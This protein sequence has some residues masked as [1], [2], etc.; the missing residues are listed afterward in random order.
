[1]NSKKL[2]TVGIVVLNYNN[3]QD[4][5]ECVDSILDQ[6][7]D[8]FELCIVDNHSTD[9]SYTQLLQW[10]ENNFSYNKPK[11]SPIFRSNIE[12]KVSSTTRQKHHKKVHIIQSDS[13]SGYAAGNNIGLQYLAAFESITYFW[14][15]NNDT[16]ITSDALTK[17]NDSFKAN[18]ATQ[19]GNTGILAQKL[20][21]YQHPKKI[22]ALGGYLTRPFMTSNHVAEGQNDATSEILE[23]F[24]TQVEYPVGA[25]MFFSRRF[26]EHA[27]Y[28]NEGYFLYYEE[29]D[30]IKRSLNKAQTLG[31]CLDSIVFHKEG[32]TTSKSE[33]ISRLSYAYAIRNRVRYAWRNEQLYFP[34]TLLYTILVLIKHLIS[35]RYK[36][37]KRVVWPK[38]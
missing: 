16:V 19:S 6:D 34:L 32:A 30:W 5:M 36:L 9:D 4:T 8:L 28:M 26:L 35:G 13:N 1:M 12:A 3:A 22:Q 27:E 14:I 37:V 10:Q 31:Y 2:E 15:L 29:I 33:Q 24:L 21:D 18:Q 11:Q 7:S 23:P 17:L 20:L 25:A 38:I